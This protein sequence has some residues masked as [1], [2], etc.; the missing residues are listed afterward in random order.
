MVLSNTYSERDGEPDNDHRVDRFRTLL[1]ESDVD[2]AEP[3]ERILLRT[4][5]KTPWQKTTM[6]RQSLLG[7][8]TGAGLDLV[9]VEDVGQDVPLRGRMLSVLRMP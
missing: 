5:G 3:K 2:L 1:E 8:L 6:S 7:L 9:E 4:F